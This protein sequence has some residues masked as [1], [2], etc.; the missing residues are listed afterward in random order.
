MAGPQGEMATSG[1]R[2]IAGIE[3]VLRSIMKELESE[4]LPLAAAYV[5]MAIDALSARPET[6]IG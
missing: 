3:V 2:D 4:G 6:A 1:P 5:S